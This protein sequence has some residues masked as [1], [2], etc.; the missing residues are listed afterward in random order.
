MFSIWRHAWKENPR[1]R[2]TIFLATILGLASFYPVWLIQPYMQQCQVP[3]GWFGPIW[4]GAN[5]TV[6]I[7]SVLSHRVGSLLG[8]RGMLKLF[9]LLSFAGLFGIGLTAGLYSFLFY[10]LLTAMRGLQGP[11]SRHFLQREG[12][13]GNRASLLSLKA[14]SFR[15][16]FVVTG[17]LVGLGADQLGLNKTFQILTVV[18]IV[19]F[20]PLARSFFRL[21]CQLPALQHDKV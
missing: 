14:L 13:R 15:L 17:P 12:V 6:A 7:F 19:L 11:F 9:L 3:I 2:S 21:N 1:I 10:Y 16:G 5:L 18:F 4:A 20:I 8:D